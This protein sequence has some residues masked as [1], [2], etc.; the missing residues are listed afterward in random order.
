MNPIYRRG[1]LKKPKAFTPYALCHNHLRH[2]GEGVKAKNENRLTRARTREGKREKSRGYRSPPRAFRIFK[3][4]VSTTW[5]V[6]MQAV[7]WRSPS[8]VQILAPPQT[9]AFPNCRQE[10]RTSI[11]KKIHS[12][13][14]RK[15]K[16]K[17]H[18]Q[19]S[20][21]EQPNFAL[22][23]WLYALALVT[24]SLPNSFTMLAI[25]SYRPPF[26]YQYCPMLF[27]SQFSSFSMLGLFRP[28][29]WAFFNA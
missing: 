26:K 16:F 12:R 1:E 14:W 25:I 18:N 3:I 5:S 15:L 19:S 8:Q 29:L 6:S 24:I 11:Q 21:K 28:K 7:N 27:L 9:Q 13:S 20:S 17:L 10:K 4:E 23:G 22:V 2:T